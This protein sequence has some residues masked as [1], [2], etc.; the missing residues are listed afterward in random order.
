MYFFAGI[1]MI[2]SYTKNFESVCT[3]YA[4]C[5]IMTMN[6]EYR[7]RSVLSNPMKTFP[8]IRS[9]GLFNI[10]AFFHSK[11]LLISLKTIG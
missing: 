8:S 1:F 2:N 9:Y 3:F 4:H 7:K 6:Y 5:L 11:F 10:S